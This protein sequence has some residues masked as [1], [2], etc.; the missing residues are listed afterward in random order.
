M[1]PEHSLAQLC[2][3]LDVTRSGYHAWAQAE[4]SPHACTDAV[5]L[6][7]IRAVYAQH[8]GRYGA[9]RIQDALAKQGAHHGGKRIA[10]LMKQAGLRGLCSRRYV[11]RTTQSDHDQPIAPNRLAQR[12]A[13]TARDVG[14]RPDLCVDGG[15]LAVCGRDPREALIKGSF[16]SFNFFWMGMIL[17]RRKIVSCGLGLRVGSGWVEGVGRLFSP[18]Q[19]VWRAVFYAVADRAPMTTLTSPKSV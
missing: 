11:P 4:A 12:P 15:K 2:A 5:L 14:E 17:Q 1:K 16:S 7:K 6:P 10:R 9:P 18:F 8:Q 3:A 19:Q 13:P